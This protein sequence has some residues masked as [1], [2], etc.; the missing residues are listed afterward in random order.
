M[1]DFGGNPNRQ[2]AHAHMKQVCRQE[3][4][5]KR[6]KEDLQRKQKAERAADQLEDERHRKNVGQAQKQLEDKK[7]EERQNHRTA[8]KTAAD[9]R[10]AME[11]GDSGRWNGKENGKKKK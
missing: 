7:R 8:E 2:A 4:D 3:G 11:K 6:Q 10:K 9:R 1:A 5:K